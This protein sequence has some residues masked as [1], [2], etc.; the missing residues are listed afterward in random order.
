MANVRVLV[1][2]ATGKMGQHTINAV[3]RESH[4]ELV[5]GTCFSES[6]TEIQN[7]D[8]TTLP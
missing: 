2:G 4:L 3:N 6:G 8:D 1:S 5:G 7:T